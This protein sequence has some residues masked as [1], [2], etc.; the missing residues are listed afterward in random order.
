ML[1][2]LC[3]VRRRVGF[4]VL[5][6]LESDRESDEESSLR[7]DAITLLIGELCMGGAGWVYQY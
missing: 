4:E 7:A 3:G 2:G 1:F 6:I 5:Y